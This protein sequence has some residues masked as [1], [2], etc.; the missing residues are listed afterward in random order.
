MTDSSPT[1]RLWL[2]LALTFPLFGVQFFRYNNAT[3]QTHLAAPMLV[4]GLIAVLG[5]FERAAAR[6]SSSASP[7]LARRRANRVLLL[8]Y[9]FLLAHVLSLLLAVDPVYG[10]REVYKLALGLICLSAIVA[11]FPRDVRFLAKFWTI[12]VWS[13]AGLAL[14][15]LYQSAVVF[16]V[17]YLVS[18]FGEDSRAAKNQLAGLLVYVFPFAIGYA[19]SPG[20]ANRLGQ[21]V[22]ALVL[23]TALL[24][25]G[26]RGGW[27]ATLIGMVVA[28]S[29]MARAYGIRRVLGPIVLVMIALAAGSLILKAS[30][31]IERLD[32]Q[33]RLQ[34]FYDPESVPEF[35]TVNQRTQR[36]MGA[37]RMFASSPIIG[38]GLSNATA[39]MGTL[40]HND[41][42]LMLGELGLVGTLLF[43][44]IASV[45]VRSMKVPRVPAEGQWLQSAWR[46][47]LIGELVFMLSMDRIYSTTLFWAFV[48]VSL[49]TAEI[50]WASASESDIAIPVTRSPRVSW[51]PAL[52]PP[53]SQE[54]S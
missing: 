47:G 33:K 21:W 13:T 27:V 6:G 26:S 17:P 39:V 34:F 22:P 49:V 31:D 35:D 38:V 37:L 15:L 7:G 52:V 5:A 20:R 2:L 18:E 42:A 29:M 45:L 36:V 53:P 11:L 3:L 4:L 23:A 51:R 54:P 14:Y 19:V 16:N 43:G 9:I 8:G 46:A 30:V 10:I 12:V 28:S 1:R 48:G 44:I 40:P 24:Y 50:E 41:Y 25:N 32:Y